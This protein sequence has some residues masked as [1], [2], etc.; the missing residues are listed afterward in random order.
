MIEEN[1][2]AD[3]TRTYNNLMSRCNKALTYTA[4][5]YTG[6]DPAQFITAI[7]T[8]GSNSRDLAMAYWFTQDKKYAQKSIEIIKLGLK[9]AGT[10]P[11]WRMRVVPCISPEECIQCSV[12]MICC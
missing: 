4:N 12:L 11:M 7:Y 2:S 3:I 9:H 8:P 1:R 5:P 10:S 6:Q